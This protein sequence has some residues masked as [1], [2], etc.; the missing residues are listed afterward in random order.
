MNSSASSCGDLVVD[1]QPPG[2]GVS[3]CE[4]SPERLRVVNPDMWATRVPIY[5]F[6]SVG[7]ACSVCFFRSR[8][9]VIVA[10][11]PACSSVSRR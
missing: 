11:T 7:S 2:N 3:G 4:L 8:R 6:R 9:I 1:V 10:P 5:C